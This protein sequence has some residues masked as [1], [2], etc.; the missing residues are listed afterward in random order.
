MAKNE[1]LPFA[2][3]EDANV[4]PTAQWE[5]LTDILENGFQSGIAKSEQVNRVLAQGAVASYVLGQLIVDQLNKDAT[6]DKDTLYQ[7]IVQALQENAKD[8]CL[9]LSGGTV[10]GNVY[11]G[12]SISQTTDSAIWDIT[13]GTTYNK[14]AY[15]SLSGKDSSRGGRFDLVAHNGTNYK[16]LV[17]TAS[18]ALTWGGTNIVRSVNGASANTNGEVTISVPSPKA[19]VTE[20]YRSGSTWYRKWSDGFIE[21]GGTCTANTSVTVTFPVAFAS[22]VLNA[23]VCAY[24]V[25]NDNAEYLKLSSTPTLT[26][27]V[28]RGGYTTPNVYGAIKA[29]GYWYACGY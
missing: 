19:Y 18:G 17:G 14:G 2:N 27:L 4:L 12:S 23:W 26:S 10:T 20:T 25:S 13:G 16:N 5:A 21:Q 1:L 7:N 22:V 28:A 8:A 24:G 3:G 11:F 6:L 9:P 15:L 29:T